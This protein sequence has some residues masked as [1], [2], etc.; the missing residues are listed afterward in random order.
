MIFSTQPISICHYMSC[1]DHTIDPGKLTHEKLASPPWPDKL[2]L[3][4]GMK[5]I[6]APDTCLMEST[7]FT[8]SPQRLVR[9]TPSHDS[10]P[11]PSAIVWKE[12]PTRPVVETQI[13]ATSIIPYLRFKNH[14]RR[15][16]DR[17][18]PGV[19]V[20]QHWTP[21]TESP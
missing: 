15:I 17:L 9:T 16:L 20:A 7:S 6:G 18:N 21:W 4:F 2:V 13:R 19:G 11:H 3:N 1:L 12:T 14:E 10:L 5:S 8:R